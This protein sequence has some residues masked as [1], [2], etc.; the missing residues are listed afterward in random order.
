MAKKIESAAVLEAKHQQHRESS[1]QQVPYKRS[2]AAII[3]VISQILPKT[4]SVA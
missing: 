4:L 3:P 2:S 1:T